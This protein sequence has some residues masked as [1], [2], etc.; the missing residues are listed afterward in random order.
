MHDHS[1][2]VQQI[3]LSHK[4]STTY[5]TATFHALCIE[6]GR[7]KATKTNCLPC[8]LC[9]CYYKQIFLQSLNTQR[10]IVKMKSTFGTKPRDRN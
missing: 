5:M 4:L 2:K 10:I 7:K 9:S 8:T 6:S 3:K 1:N